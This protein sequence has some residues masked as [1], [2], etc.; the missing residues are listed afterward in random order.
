MLFDKI[1]I[2]M[3]FSEESRLLLNCLE[4]FKLLGLKEVILAHVVDIRAAGG[5]ASSFVAPNQKKLQEKK[6]EI[7]NSQVRCKTVVQIGFPAEEIDSIARQ[8]DASLILIGSHGRGFIKSFFLGSTAFDLL[9]I[10]Q[11]PLLVERFREQKGKLKPYCRYKFAK[12]LAATDFSQCASKLVETMEAH[13]KSFQEILLM[14]VIERAYSKQEFDKLKA[15]AQAILDEIKDS[16]SKEAEVYTRIKAGDA[17]KNI[18]ETA[19][20]EEATLIMLTKK[21]RGG[22]KEY[23]L[24]STARDVALRSTRNAVLI[25]PC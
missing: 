24:G 16:L 14:H 11:T 8:H 3:D 13:Q 7:E 21:G 19:Q 5:N 2:S 10:T 18:I 23:L 1:L 22:T 4:E 6:K 15:D 20:K 9:R 12:V 17:A 25:I